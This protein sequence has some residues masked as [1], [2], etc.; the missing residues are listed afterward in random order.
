MLSL[1]PSSQEPLGE[2]L[3]RGLRRAIAEGEVAR[4]ALLPSVR[5]LAS[6]L[7]VNLNTVARAYRD[8]EREGLVRTARG[9]GT[10]VVADRAAARLPRTE[11]RA[12]VRDLLADAT[13]AGYSADELRQVLFEEVKRRME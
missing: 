13:L 2:Q 11:L 6:D 3:R 9:R 5:Q 1:D 7:G 8:L 12:R 10:T 4:G